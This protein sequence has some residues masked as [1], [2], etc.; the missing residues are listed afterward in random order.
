[1]PQPPANGT[2][3]ITGATAGLGAGFARQLAAQGYD[4][5]LVARDGRRLTEVAGDLTA[6]HRVTA[7]P[8]V[9]DLATDEGCAAVEQRLRATDEPVELLVNNAGFS[10]NTPFIRSTAADEARLLHVN[11][12][13]V[14]RLTLAVLPGMAERGHGDVINVSSVAG[15][16]A[17]MPGSTYPATKAWVTNFSQSVALS[18][19][20]KGIRVMAL[21]PGFVRTE[22][23]RRA[24][25]DPTATPRWLWLDVDAVV[26]D[27]LR[28]LRRGALV[29]VPDWR[30]KLAVALGRHAPSALLRRVPRLTRG[31]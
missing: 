1:M 16:F 5:V 2:A 24:G 21:C 19:R 27:A 29:S 4:L 7:T 15:F 11:V 17:V 8:L 20:H 30:Y 22:F 25:I 3:L 18:V 23:H 14:M 26:R 9:A 31:R 28:D 10:L 13:A 6:R 12:E